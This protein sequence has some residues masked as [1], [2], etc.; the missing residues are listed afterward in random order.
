MAFI[1]EADIQQGSEV[2][3]AFVEEFDSYNINKLSP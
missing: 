1:S 2:E 3:K